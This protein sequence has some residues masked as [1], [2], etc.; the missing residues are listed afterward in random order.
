VGYGTQEKK[1]LTSAVA[2]VK[3][4]DFN[5]GT[6]NDPVQL[7]QGKVAGLNITR[8]GGNPNGGFN[9]RL[10]GVSTFGA[11]S[12]PLIV[13]DG[14][15]GGSLNTV[16]PND[17]ASIDVLK[18]ASAAAIYGSRGGSGVILITTKS[19]KQGRVTVEYNGS[20]AVETI[21]NKI[22]VMTADEYL[23]VP[24][25]VNLGSKT[26][27]LDEVTRN[28][29]YM[30]HNLSLSGGTA[31]TTYRASFNYRRAEGIAINSG[32]NQING[33]LTLTQKALKD[34][35][36]FTFG[37]STTSKDAIYGFDDSFRYAIVANPTMP[38]YDNTVD[39]PTHGAQYG[40]YA[41]R[42]IFDFYNPVSIAEQNK[43]D[44]TDTRFLVSLKANYDFSDIAP[45]LSA[46]AFYSEQRESDIRGYFRAKTA[47][48]GGRNGLGTAGRGLDQRKN[49][50]FE[51]TINYN[52]QFG[53]ADVT[54]LGGYSYQDFYNEGFGM[55]GG[56]FLTDAFTYNNM[57]TALDFAMD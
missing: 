39:S 19:G 47:K 7:L 2:S 49:R 22:R 17:I 43:N 33:R 18:D 3:S 28:G 10:R 52:H 36:T 35:A 51:T 40:G 26:D 8:P 4:E 44:G 20:A 42:D 37:L 50:L 45:G 38:V 21:A 5:K 57:G 25:A 30:V 34:R 54:V 53:A 56:N 31:S 23:Q 16:D 29:N 12:E 55:A 13:I 6:V 24:G 15:I 32:F 41:E 14:V 46:S 27:W 1:E 9:V 48:F 11:N